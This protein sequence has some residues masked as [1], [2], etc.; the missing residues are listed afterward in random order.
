MRLADFLHKAVQDN[1]DV[2][3]GSFVFRTHIPEVLSNPK[4]PEYLFAEFAN[5]GQRLRARLLTP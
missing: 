3:T 2:S 5:S 4:Y 1:T